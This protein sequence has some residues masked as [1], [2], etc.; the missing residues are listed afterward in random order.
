VTITSEPLLLP[1]GRPPI[2]GIFAAAR[3]HWPFVIVPTIVAFALAAAIGYSIKP[4][5]TAQATMNVGRLD[6]N[7]QSIPGYAL[8]IQNLAAAYARLVTADGVVGPVAAKLHRSI[9]QVRGEV[10]GSPVALAPLLVVTATG[11]TQQGTVNLANDVAGSLATY[12][13]NLN[14]GGTDAQHLNL[15]GSDA[16]TLLTQYK[17]AVNR[18]NELFG[19]LSVLQTKP[20]TP[21]NNREKLALQTAVQGQSLQVDA[22]KT[23]YLT[24]QQGLGSAS[25]V[26]VLNKSQF[27]SSNHHTRIEEL[28]FAGLV[29]GLLV[30]LGL[31]RWR[32]G[33]VR[34]RILAA[35]AAS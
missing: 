20:N 28:G 25:I 22:L 33:A 17:P 8:A 10:N 27:A 19:Q 5:Y 31:A 1:P 32:Y 12:V 3:R 29:L 6:V 18:L 16:Q 23:A 34:R 35:R 26:Q 24:S 21:A 11:S 14:L 9:G 13:A 7:T 30:G 4:V 15:G 2:R